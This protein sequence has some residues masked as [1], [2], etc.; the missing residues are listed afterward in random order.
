MREREREGQMR[1]DVCVNQ[2]DTREGGEVSYIWF[3]LV[4]V[5]QPQTCFKELLS[6]GAL[7]STLKGVHVWD[8]SFK[9]ETFLPNLIC[10]NSPR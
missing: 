4:L 6:V 2:A 9:S 10:C 8:V 5:K 3:H 7:Q 1:E